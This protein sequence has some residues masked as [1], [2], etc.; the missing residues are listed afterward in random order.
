MTA[1]APAS[2][3]L[4]MRPLRA[5][6]L[7][8]IAASSG[9]SAAPPAAEQLASDSARLDE[10][11]AVPALLKKIGRELEALRLE[12][13]PSSLTEE[14][15]QLLSMSQDAAGDLAKN[16]DLPHQRQFK[17]L[18]DRIAEKLAPTPAA[19]IAHQ[20]AQHRHAVARARAAADRIAKSFKPEDGDD[21]DWW[22]P[23]PAERVHES[24]KALAAMI[25]A[26]EFDGLAT[27]CADLMTLGDK[28]SAAPLATLL[29]K[30]LGSK[31]K[32]TVL[33]ALNILAGPAEEDL[34][35][36]RLFD[37][38][39]DEAVR[40]AA[41]KILSPRQRKFWDRPKAQELVKNGPE[42]LRIQIISQD[43]SFLTVEERAAQAGVLLKSASSKIR[44]DAVN[45]IGRLD[46]KEYA[47]P[48]CEFLVHTDL[49]ERSRAMIVLGQLSVK[50]TFPTLARFA[51]VRTE[52][53]GLRLRALE[54]LRKADALGPPYLRRDQLESLLEN[55]ISARIA[56]FGLIGLGKILTPADHAAASARLLEWGSATI[57]T[58]DIIEAISNFPDKDHARLIAE[59][60]K[61]DDPRIQTSALEALNKM[62]FA[63]Q[64]ASEAETLLE[65]ADEATV[66]AAIDL[67]SDLKIQKDEAAFR[68]TLERFR[69]DRTADSTLDFQVRLAALQALRKLGAL[70]ASAEEAAALKADRHH[71]MAR[72]IIALIGL[73][74]DDGRWIGS[75][76]SIRNAKGQIDRDVATSAL[77]LEALQRAAA[78]GLKHGTVDE[79]LRLKVAAAED[80]GDKYLLS[81]N[82]C[83]NGRWCGVR[84]IRYGFALTRLAH[85]ETEEAHAA[86]K[87]ILSDLSNE[88][89]ADGG[90]GYE[91]NSDHTPFDTAIVIL[92]ML[93]AAKRRPLSA[94]DNERLDR[95]AAALDG[96]HTGGQWRYSQKDADFA[97]GIGSAGRNP[98][99]ALALYRYYAYA[100]KPFEKKRLG[101]AIQFF[102]KHQPTLEDVAA[103]G[104]VEV[105]TGP[106]D[107]S[108]YF[109]LFG[110]RYAAAALRQTD[111]EDRE[112]YAEKLELAL[113]RGQRRAGN[114]AG[115]WRDS[116]FSG[117][118]ASTAFA[119]LSLVDLQP[120]ELY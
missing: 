8:F 56:V 57:E 26:G 64:Y 53:T 82:N 52:D 42:L 92:G 87:Q 80:K 44:G 111:L 9:W 50:D 71:A 24:P 21:D 109:F 107:T 108:D 79:T 34:I 86:V 89:K 66:H 103:A 105:H 48:L 91:G 36:E 14:M 31:D 88:E 98:L 106:G 104:Q 11:P 84:P 12:L 61:K 41:W 25:E 55:K 23:P 70:D 94:G 60:M 58:L 17:L 65:S 73:Q 7:L 2:I 83:G 85:Q 81:S 67:L 77:A 29:R 51:M 113:L 120:S 3:L 101:E 118:A 45:I 10:G 95:A 27:V 97:V 68:K 78:L 16:P 38:K 6:L 63:R 33:A 99:C 54:T 74:Q 15:V 47:L 4:R 75:E 76:G 116:R 46:A 90:Y 100:H 102:M 72:A 19:A 22:T 114:D 1:A 69:I 43:D 32:L 96:I 13:P 115:T 117:A 39:E 119:L 40:A 28:Q 49:E 62:G 59:Q 93:D 110:M 112:K 37:E 30:N 5:A 35:S 18:L 20:S